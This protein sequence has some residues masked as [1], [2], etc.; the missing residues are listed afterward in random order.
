M[1]LVAAGKVHFILFEYAFK[2]FCPGCVP[3]ALS[4]RAAV[5]QVHATRAVGEMPPPAPVAR[6]PHAGTVTR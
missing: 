6:P 1:A 4:Q 2:I 3:V 5:W